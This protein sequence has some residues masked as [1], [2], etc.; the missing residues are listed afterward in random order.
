M[1]LLTPQ[2]RLAFKGQGGDLFAVL[3]VNWL[4]T[5]VTLGLYYPWAKVRRLKYYYEHTE[6][7]DHPFHFHG[8][9]REMFI[10]F[11]KAVGLL[12]L[13]Y[14]AFFGLAML[15]EAWASVLGFLVLFGGLLL[16]LPLIIHGTYRY[17]MSR[18][19]W[20]GIHFGYRGDRNELYRICLRDGLLTLV[21]LG[22]YGSWFT[23]NLRNYVMSHVRWGSSQF[24]YK[25]DGLDF[26]LM[27]L[28]G[29]FLTLFTLG[30]YG[31]WWQK[32]MFHYYVDH[33]SW[34]FTDG[35]RLQFKGTATG[36]GFFGLIIT[37]VLLVIFTL[38]IGYAWAEVRTMRYIL[39]NI[40]LV[41]DAD[42]NNV[43]QTEQEHKGA[44]AEELGD[45]MDIGI[46]L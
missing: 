12:A 13:L 1:E 29:Y 17:R 4:L 37:N 24:A 39:A 3:I 40:T 33:L 14:G 22:I 31:F 46:F 7:D 44:L 23:I 30:I 20:R 32:D 21:T 15:Q 18:S 28:K 27:N 10:G 2:R 26:F 25:G 34:T 43:A 35:K 38:G 36:G 5:M 6:L 8:T 9:G 11:I 45:L 16:L 19:S 41:G 42:L